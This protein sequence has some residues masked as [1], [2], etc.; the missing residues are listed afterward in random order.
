MI[1]TVVDSVVQELIKLNKI[2]EELNQKITLETSPNMTSEQE[3][4]VA[5][6]SDA[7][8]I[9]KSYIENSYIIGNTYFVLMPDGKHNNKVVEMRLY[10]INRKKRCC[11][12]F[13]AQLKDTNCPNPDLVLS[14]ETNL[15]LRVYKT[16]E[17]A[18]KNK[19]NKLWRRK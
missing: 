2:I 6:L 15:K 14:N 16:K 18:E 17:E 3:Y 7:L 8:D 11:Y 9:I 5:G 13:T 1:Q 19:D 4:Y 12:C 10:K